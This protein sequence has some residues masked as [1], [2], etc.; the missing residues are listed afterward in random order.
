MYRTRGELLIAFCTISSYDKLLN[1]VVK[2]YSF[3]II[4]FKIEETLKLIK[5]DRVEQ[6]SLS[7]N[8]NN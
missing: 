5:H 2:Y 3:L 4:E 6:F 1:I 8:N 7:F